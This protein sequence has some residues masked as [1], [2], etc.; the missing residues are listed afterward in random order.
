MLRVNARRCLFAIIIDKSGVAVHEPD[1]RMLCKYRQHLVEK[2]RPIPIVAVDARH[3]CA[4]RRMQTIRDSCGMPH[5]A[6]MPDIFDARIG[7]GRDDFVRIIGGRVVD[8]DD[9]EIMIAFLAENATDRF[10]DESSVVVGKH[11][12]RNE[13]LTHALNAPGAMTSGNSMRKRAL[14]SAA[15]R[16][17]SATLSISSLVIV[18]PAGRTSTRAI[19]PS[20]C[21][22]TG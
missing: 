9:L 2:V 5:I 16:I 1:I 19:T 17:K 11:D 18:A 7:E 21:G 8:Y 15:V 22:S 4:T 12:K 6:R 13:R 10:A 3:V 14:S 20:V